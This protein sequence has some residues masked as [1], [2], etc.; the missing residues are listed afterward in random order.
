MKLL[1]YDSSVMSLTYK[2]ILHR[3]SLRLISILSYRK[4]WALLPQ[5]DSIRFSLRSVRFRSGSTSN[6]CFRIGSVPQ[7]QEPITFLVATTNINPIFSNNVPFDENFSTDISSYKLAFPIIELRK[8]CFSGPLAFQGVSN[9][10]AF[11]KMKNQCFGHQKVKLIWK[12]VCT[13]RLVE[14]QCCLK[15]WEWS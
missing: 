10:P 13:G 14:N 8:I 15:K 6:L 5:L 9:E 12:Y 4:F 3:G 7:K 11:L 1:Q 2:E